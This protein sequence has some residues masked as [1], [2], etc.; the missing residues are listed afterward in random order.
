MK[1]MLLPITHNLVPTQ[2][3][4]AKWSNSEEGTAPAALTLQ[5]NKRQ[6]EDEITLI[7]SLKWI[8]KGSLGSTVPPFL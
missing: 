8:N 1:L 5:W 3:L 2:E 7:Q 4:L 6:W